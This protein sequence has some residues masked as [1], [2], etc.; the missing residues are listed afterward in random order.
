MFMCLRT[1]K[2]PRIS[3]VRLAPT[4]PD[5]WPGSIINAYG[6]H[7]V[8]GN[9]HYTVIPEVDRRIISDSGLS[10]CKGEKRTIRVVFDI[11]GSIGFPPNYNN[12]AHA[13]VTSSAN[14]ASNVNRNVKNHFQ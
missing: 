6:L 14:D 9:L 1:E 12:L 3:T 2:L 4:R 5:K 11:V 10:F 7:G 13:T 8:S